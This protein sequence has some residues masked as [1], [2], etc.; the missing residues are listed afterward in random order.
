MS[1]TCWSESGSGFAEGFSSF[2]R[3]QDAS[4][5]RT[6]ERVLRTVSQSADDPLFIF[7]H[8]FDPHMDY[9]PIQP[10]RDYQLP[11]L[12]EPELGKMDVLLPYFD[13]ERELD[14]DDLRTVLGLYDAEI[15]AVDQAW[16]RLTRGLEA[17]GRSG[18]LVL[19]SDHGDEFEEHGSMGHGHSLLA[20]L[21]RIP[22][23]VKQGESGIRW[24]RASLLD[25]APTIAAALEVPR[26]RAWRGSN[27]L[28][29]VGEGRPVLAENRL[30]GRDQAMVVEGDGKVV[31]DATT[32]ET[33]R[34]DL[35]LDPRERSPRT[36][37]EVP[38]A[39]RWLSDGFRPGLHRLGVQPENLP[40]DRIGV[41]PQIPG[42]FHAWLGD[43]EAEQK[44]PSWAIPDIGRR[45]E[46]EGTTVQVEVIPNLEELEDP[47]D[48]STLKSLGYLD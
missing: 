21:I 33:Q 29:G 14:P 36:G 3:Q 11:A 46:E 41:D 16:G 37:V 30:F 17:M 8:L 32:G 6:V 7:L 43:G 20:E 39:A 47:E 35:S 2:V 1:T 27:L 31:L 13:R 24:D 40:P 44:V 26:P 15:Q 22:L 48:L 18:P 9:A 25:V 34:F 4:A 42:V 28:G 10:Y 45:V 5:A 23:I 12:S 38:P 19:T